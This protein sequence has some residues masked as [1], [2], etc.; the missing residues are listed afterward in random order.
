MLYD[1]ATDITLDLALGH[2]LGRVL[3]PAPLDR[4]QA[5]NERVLENLVYCAQRHNF[6]PL[7]HVLGDLGEVFFVVGAYS[8]LAIS[9]TVT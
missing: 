4:H 7:C 5:G 8:I 1:A 6:E 2:G 3:V 9:A